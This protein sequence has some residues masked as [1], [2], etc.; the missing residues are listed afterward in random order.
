MSDMVALQLVDR[1]AEDSYTVASHLSAVTPMTVADHL[2]RQF[3][4]HAVCRELA[5]ID[6]DTPF[7]PEVIEDILRK[8]GASGARLSETVVHQYAMTIRRWLLFSGHIEQKGRWFSRPTGRGSSMGLLT[9]RRARRML[10]LGCSTPDAVL[11][12]VSLLAT[13]TDGLPESQILTDGARNAL[14]DA[15]S[16]DL[17]TRSED[18][19]IYS[20]RGAAD[21]P[22]MARQVAK[23]ILA[24]ETVQIIASVLTVNSRVSNSEL[25]SE[26]SVQLNANWKSS[27]AMRYANGIRGFYAWA[28]THEGT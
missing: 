20:V 6:R 9:G 14:Y 13:T 25:G 2:Q 17:A 7:P 23:S 28:C 18:K 19:R 27:S 12:L 11:R 4:R 16:L 22:V 26:L 10:F 21:A 3:A 24:A 1:V 15:I 8:L 5:R